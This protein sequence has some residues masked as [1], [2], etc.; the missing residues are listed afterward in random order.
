MERCG[1]KLISG[2]YSGVS[3]DV[4]EKIREIDTEILE[5]SDATFQQG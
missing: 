3:R 1:T 4:E 5:F 2:T